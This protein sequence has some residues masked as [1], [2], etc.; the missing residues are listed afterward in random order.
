MES[1]EV[2][3]DRT[4]L[5]Q[6]ATFQAQHRDGTWATHHREVYDRG[7]GVAILLTDPAAGTVVL[8]RQFRAPAYLN[9][10]PDGMLWEVPAG[11]D[12]GEAAEA[13]IRREVRE[14]TGYEVAAARRL[15]ELF[16]SPGAVTERITFFAA[17]YTSGDRV[18]PGGGAPDEG[19]DIEVVELAL[20]EAWA[21]V[22]AGE[23]VDAKTVILLQWARTRDC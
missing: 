13:A 19:E 17:D 7:N 10:H 20:D 8:T 2:L 9:G 21:M 16:M 12:D 4:Y 15:F 22:E 1:L 3:S 5:L 6:R 23:I 18:G 11:L 14:E